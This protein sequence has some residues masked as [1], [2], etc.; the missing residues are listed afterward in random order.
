MMKFYRN[1]KFDDGP[2]GCQHL[3]LIVLCQ[4]LKVAHFRFSVIGRQVRDD[5]RIIG[6]DND[7]S[8][9]T[10]GECNDAHWTTD[11]PVSGACK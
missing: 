2:F 4:F 3:V 6:V 7:D 1:V 11:S 10:P 8:D 9:Q 5:A